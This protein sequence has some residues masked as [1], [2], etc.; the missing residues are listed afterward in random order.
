MNI[1]DFGGENM[2]LDIA[3]AQRFMI[4]KHSN[5]LRK[6]GE[7]YYHHPLAVSNMLK[8]HGFSLSYQITGLFHDLLEDT[9]T[10]LKEIKAYSNEEVLQAVQLLTKFKG[11]IMENYIYCIS[12]NEMAKMTKL[13]DR[14]DNLEPTSFKSLD[15]SFRKKYIK[16]TEDYYTDLYV[17]TPFF[18][19]FQKTMRQ[20][21]NR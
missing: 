20:I 13:A 8:L 15:W 21:K 12:Q 10:S 1:N 18:D 14:L 3:A 5:Q 16:E 6:N 19:D 7:L 4:E 9:D 17:N 11:Y 2:E